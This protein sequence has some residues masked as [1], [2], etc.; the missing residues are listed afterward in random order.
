[1]V[2]ADPLLRWNPSER[3]VDYRTGRITTKTDSI[4]A[5]EAFK[6]IAGV[7]LR[8]NRQ[9]FHIAAIDDNGVID[10]SPAAIEFVATVGQLP[11]MRFTTSILKSDGTTSSTVTAPYDPSVLDTVGMF[12][13]FW[14]SY[15]GKTVNGQVR[16]Y[17]YYPLTATVTL[18][19]QDVWSDDLSDTV[20]SFPNSGEDLIP[21]GMFRF[22][23]QCR[24]DA[25]AESR[26]DVKSF[27]EGVV[28]LAINYEPDTRIFNAVSTYYVFFQ[29]Y[30]D[31]I[32]FLDDIPD[33]VP[34]NSWLRIDYRG[35]DSP[36]DSSLCT[37]DVNKCLGYQV[38][39][40]RT[41]S[42]V[43]GASSK[44]R[45]LPDEPED[46]NP[47][48]VA[49]STS[50]NMGSVEYEIHARSVDEYGKA[51]GTPDQ[52]EIIGNYDPTLDSAELVNW[53]GTVV[54][55]FGTTDTLTW[56]WTHPSNF[57]DSGPHI[58][59]G[60]GE[61]YILKKYHFDINATGHDHPKE[62]INFGVRNW[63]YLFNRTD[64]GAP[65]KFGRSRAWVAGPSPNLLSDRFSIEY[66]YDFVN[67]PGGQSIMQN[68]PSF[69]DSEYYFSIYGRDIPMGE[70][71][72][73]FMFVSQ[74]KE[75][76]NSYQ[77][78]ALGRWTETLEFDFYLRMER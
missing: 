73:Q 71:F 4:F 35:W 3:L 55:P 49:D 68:P 30:T 64:T 19:G 44:S 12:R 58:D 50:M 75:K 39:Y 78:A 70:E 77:A 37:D 76:L 16:E 43:P 61:I 40:S 47:F 66:R 10:P 29:A 18:P 45:W 7:G 9:A 15:H 27:E 38:Q 33:T 54:G 52:I 65:Q 22:A 46:N 48:G 36:Y 17:I 25:G 20:R 14:I 53:D 23:A 51:D 24:D 60:T 74:E 26:T 11:E 34:Y 72:E 31:T 42:R 32:N 28:Q 69:W 21:S 13:P 41:S 8:K 6:N 57:N 56:D 1:T 5:F 62:N 63:Y 2:V 67:D 59:F